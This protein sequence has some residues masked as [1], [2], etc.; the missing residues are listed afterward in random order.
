MCIEDRGSPRDQICELDQVFSNLSRR[1]NAL[2]TKHRFLGP[3]P[4]DLNVLPYCMCVGLGWRICV[5][6]K[7]PGLDADAAGSWTVL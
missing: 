3:T 4:R 1:K 5:S 2:R 7:A 6:N